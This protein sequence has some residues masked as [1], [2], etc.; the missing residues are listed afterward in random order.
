[1]TAALQAGVYRHHCAQSP[2]TRSM[3]ELSGSDAVV[4]TSVKPAWG[5]ADIVV[6]LWNTGPEPAAAEVRLD[7]PVRAAWLCNLNEQ[8][9]G[10]LETDDGGIRAE[11][12]ALGLVT[13]RIRL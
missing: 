6:R 3:V 9:R 4:V 1:M 8:K 13:V 7:A 10:E 11:V 5:S 2:G 12:P